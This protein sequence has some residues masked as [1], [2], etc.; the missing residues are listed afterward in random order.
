ML[1]VA[2]TTLLFAAPADDCVTDPNVL[3]C[4]L[5]DT[6][7]DGIA[8]LFDRCPERPETF[9]G[10]ADDDGCPDSAPT[11]IHAH[12]WSA[13]LKI[14]FAGN[15]A[16]LRGPA[17][18]HVVRLAAMLRD[19][20]E[21]FKLRGNAHACE[22]DSP[23]ARHVLA[24]HRAEAVRNLLIALGIAAERITTAVAEPTSPCDPK[25]SATE[26]R[27]QT[28]IDLCDPDAP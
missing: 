1:P 28:R 17:R 15:S 8:D 24:L 4:P 13:D 16:A 22:G 19:Q 14:R 21:P 5:P 11:P 18:R 3:G 2:L 27:E 12:T 25:S 26:R 10:H 23:E 6:D 9:Q 7:A 20:V